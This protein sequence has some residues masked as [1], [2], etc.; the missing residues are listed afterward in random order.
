[1]K[2]H[3]LKQLA[4]LLTVATLSTQYPVPQFRPEPSWP[5]IPNNW[6]FGEVSSIAVDKNDHV[7]ILHRPRTVP[8][9]QQGKA[10][11]PVLEFESSGRYIQSWGGPANGYDW[12]ER[13]HGI[14]VDPQGFVWIGG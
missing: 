14:Y 13:E 5:A 3:W 10:A 4:L 1:M 9:E 2:I 6:V 8:A 11:P 7:W 12:P